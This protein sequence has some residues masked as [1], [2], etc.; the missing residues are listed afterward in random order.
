VPHHVCRFAPAD[1]HRVKSDRAELFVTGAFCIVDLGWFVEAGGLNVSLA[2]TL[3]DVDLCLRANEQG[4]G[5][6]YLGRDCYL[7]HG[8]GTTLGP[9][10]LQDRQF[11]SDALL[12]SKLWKDERILPVLTGDLPTWT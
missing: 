3:Q 12:Y 2:R 10:G 1:H 6:M 11:A 7:Y 5:V 4:R 8:E 9:D